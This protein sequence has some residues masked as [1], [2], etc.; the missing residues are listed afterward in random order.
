[1]ATTTKYYVGY[2]HET[3][4]DKKH[5]TTYFFKANNGIDAK[6]HLETTAREWY[7]EDGDYNAEHDAY[8]FSNE[9]LVSSGRFKEIS[10]ST[11]DELSFY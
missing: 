6:S 10:K 7:G 1:M 9:V 5:T 2:I 3:N 11:F 4:G 8:W